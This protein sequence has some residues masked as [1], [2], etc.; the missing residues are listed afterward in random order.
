MTDIRTRAADI[1]EPHIS[2]NFKRRER[3]ESNAQTL[4]HYGLLGTLK[5]KFRQLLLIK[6]AKPNGAQI[7][8]LDVGPRDRN[9]KFFV[10]R[11]YE[12]RRNADLESRCW[13]RA[14]VDVQQQLFAIT[15]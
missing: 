8:K 11:P 4:D 15:I 10:R 1:I 6:V 14:S 3:A 5:A 7:R 12:P 9:S 2:G 13:N